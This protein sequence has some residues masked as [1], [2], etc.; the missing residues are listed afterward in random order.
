MHISISSAHLGM[1]VAFTAVASYTQNPPALII[2]VDLPDC[3]EATTARM[4]SAT[5]ATQL[6]SVGLRRAGASAEASALAN[7][8]NETSP[9]ALLS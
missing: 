8:L 4:T 7:G 3:Y 1:P 9:L 5:L 2:S 6:Y